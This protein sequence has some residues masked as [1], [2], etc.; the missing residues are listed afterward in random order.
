MLILCQ[1]R[2]R[3]LSPFLKIYTAYI[4]L[5]HTAMAKCQEAKKLSST[6]AVLAATRSQPLWLRRDEKGRL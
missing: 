4:S 1:P 3:P 2:R 6:F 5:S